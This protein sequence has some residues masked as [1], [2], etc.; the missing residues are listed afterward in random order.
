MSVFGTLTSTVCP[1]RPSCRRKKWGLA[2]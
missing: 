2:A 1:K